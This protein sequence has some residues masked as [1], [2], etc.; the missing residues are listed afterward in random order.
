MAQG[1]ERVVAA[2]RRLFEQRGYAGTSLRDVASEVG[3]TVAAVYHH[4]PTKERL[5]EE[6]TRPL[7]D[8]IETVV[9]HAELALQPGAAGLDTA[10]RRRLLC[11]YVDGL[12][13]HLEAARL[14]GRDAALAGTAADVRQTDLRARLYRL[15]GGG[16]HGHRNGDVLASGAIGVLLRPVLSL[17]AEAV[18]AAREQLVEAAVALTEDDPQRA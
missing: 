17:G 5:L 1:R 12:L 14:L 2:A 10:A 3:V 9:S 8:S 6:V 16:P 11:G 13:G 18:R 15:L 7:L 4:F